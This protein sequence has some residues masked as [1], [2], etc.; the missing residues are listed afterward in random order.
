[1][2]MIGAVL[3]VRCD[4]R[5]FMLAGCCQIFLSVNGVEACECWLIVTCD[6]LYSEFHSAV[7]MHMQHI[8]YLKNIFT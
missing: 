7:Q 4:V 6:L 5:L 2:L 1:M 3:E 8:P